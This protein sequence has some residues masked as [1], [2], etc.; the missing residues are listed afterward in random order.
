MLGV[1]DHEQW[2]VHGAGAQGGDEREGE[3]V[4]GDVLPA[5]AAQGAGAVGGARRRGAAGDVQE[6]Q[7]QGLRRRL[8]G[9]IR[10]RRAHHRL[11]Q[12]QGR[13]PAAAA[14]GGGGGRLDQ[15]VM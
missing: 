1:A 8:L 2:G 15:R 13:A 11:P 9:R 6:A 10:R 14:G 5:G 3:D 7:G 12:G 4:G